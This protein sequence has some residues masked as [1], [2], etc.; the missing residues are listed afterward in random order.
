M[1]TKL[2][3]KLHPCLWD[4]IVVLTVAALAIVL[5]AALVRQADAS[6]G[7]LTCTI[8]QN[9]RILKSVDL[10][11]IPD[12]RQETYTVGGDYTEVIQ[13][14]RSRVRVKSSTC[15]SQDCVHTGWISKAGQSI[16]CLPNRLVV[17]LSGGSSSAGGDVDVV[18]GQQQGA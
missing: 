2:S 16:V 14:E 11:L 6:T 13:L 17:T 1:N 5:A 9:G 3:V 4:G 12:G 18:L 7:N 8:T 15:V 10:S